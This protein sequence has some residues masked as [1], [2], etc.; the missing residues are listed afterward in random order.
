MKT[1][2]NEGKRNDLK[3]FSRFVCTGRSL[4]AVLFIPSESGFYLLVLL[5]MATLVGIVYRCG[6]TNAK[7]NKMMKSKERLCAKVILT[8]IYF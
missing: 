8:N 5:W 6:G 1:T 2:E 7:E 3:H 4:S